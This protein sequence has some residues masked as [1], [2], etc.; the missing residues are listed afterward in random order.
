MVH[1]PLPSSNPNSALKNSFL[2][3][4]LLYLNPHCIFKHSWEL[5]QQLTIPISCK[6]VKRSQK[7][8]KNNM[9]PDHT[10]FL[11]RDR[12]SEVD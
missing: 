8:L 3:R 1:Q 10:V 7:S 4:L 6:D 11:K 2:W 12:T 5:K 9:L